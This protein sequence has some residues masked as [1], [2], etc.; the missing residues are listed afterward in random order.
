MKGFG[1]AILTGETLIGN[2][3]FAVVFADDL[4]VNGEEGVLRQMVKLYKKYQCSI[5]AIEEIDPSYTDK[6]GVIVGEEI[7]S[8][9]YRVSAGR[10]TGSCRCT[11]EYGNNRTLYPYLRHI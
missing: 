5:V 11:I 4:C 6:Y 2:Q 9:I 1:H 7:E 10:K 3:P 8:G